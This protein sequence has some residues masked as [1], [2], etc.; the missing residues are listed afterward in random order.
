MKWLCK[1]HNRAKYNKCFKYKTI[2]D[3]ININ[4]MKRVLFTCLMVIGLFTSCGTTQL[5]TNG[6]SY[7][8]M[9]VFQ[10][11]FNKDGYSGCLAKNLNNDLFFIFSLESSRSPNKSMN[12]L[13]YDGKN[14]SGNYVLVGT[15][16]YE[17]KSGYQKIV[18]A[19]MKKSNYDEVYTYDKDYLI[20][21]LDVI[22]EYNMVE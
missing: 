18:Q 9:N 16:S 21:M 2:F 11:L 15:Y 22:L 6:S 20:G 5:S 7:L 19:C 8:T 17:T 10:A 1:T 4:I 12:E 3:D 14:I 13:Y